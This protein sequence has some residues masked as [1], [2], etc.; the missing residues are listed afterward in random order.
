MCAVISPKVRIG[1][2]RVRHES[3]IVFRMSYIVRRETKRKERGIR[4]QPSFSS[5]SF[6]LDPKP[7]WLLERQRSRVFV[8]SLQL[9]ENLL[10]RYH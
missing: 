1:C 6:F 8:H 3:Y 4:S 5:S 10:Q 9:R 7:Y 2:D